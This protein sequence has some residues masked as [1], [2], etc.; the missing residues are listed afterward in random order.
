MAQATEQRRTGGV[1]HAEVFRQLDGDREE[2]RES[3]TG[4]GERRKVAARDGRVHRRQL[5]EVADR[6]H[7]AAAEDVVNTAR[8]LERAR[9]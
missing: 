9:Q 2:A 3:G 4:N 6:E 1:C 8:D 5:E 7:G